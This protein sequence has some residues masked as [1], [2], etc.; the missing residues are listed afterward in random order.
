MPEAVRNSLKTGIL[1]E[2]AARSYIKEKSMTMLVSTAVPYSGFRNLV[3]AITGPT[4]SSNLSDLLKTTQV[5]KAS[6]LATDTKR[7]YLTQTP[8]PARGPLNYDLDIDAYLKLLRARAPDITSVEEKPTDAKE[9]IERENAEERELQLAQL[10][11]KSSQ[12]LKD[13]YS[14]LVDEII[15]RAIFK[16]DK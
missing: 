13:P 12:R 11:T 10:K 15:T 8:T 14:I 4:S 1:D 5:I 9:R 6:D 16:M 3:F 2:G 7:F